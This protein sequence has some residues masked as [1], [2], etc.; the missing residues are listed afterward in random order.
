MGQSLV[1]RQLPQVICSTAID[2]QN[3]EYREALQRGY[4]IFHRSDVLAA[5]IREYT[6]VAVAGTHGKTTTSSMIGHLLLGAGLDPTIVVGGEVTSWGGNARLGKSPLL[7]AEADESDGTLAKLSTSIGIVTNIELDHTDHYRS[8]QD[9][10]DIFQTF[11]QQC[12]T[13]IAN[14]DCAVVRQN[15]QPQLTYSLNPHSGAT[16]WVTDVSYRRWHHRHGLGAG[17]A[18]GAASPECLRRTQPQQCPG[19]S[20]RGPLPGA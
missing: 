12:Q 13:L 8:L 18:G 7:V 6:S 17:Q 1:R 11:Q 5:L 9:V 2:E 4:P 19:G 14:W 3:P 10:V 16:Y 15:L 20:G